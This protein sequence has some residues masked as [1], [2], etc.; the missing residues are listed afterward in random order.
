MTA[1][2]PSYAHSPGPWQHVREES[3]DKGLPPDVVVDADGFYVA[4]I[5]SGLPGI[6]PEDNARLIAAAP[7]LMEVA[8]RAVVEY[9]GLLH[10]AMKRGDRDFETAWRQRLEQAEA[11]LALVEGVDIDA[12]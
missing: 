6:W 4:S 7:G 1:G 11:A 2:S 5:H 12:V 8:M 9:R 3:P 10:D